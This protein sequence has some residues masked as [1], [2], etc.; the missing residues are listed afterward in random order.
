MSE[1]FIYRALSIPVIYKLSQNIFGPRGQKDLYVKIKKI[2]GRLPPGQNLLDVGCGPSSWLWNEDRHPVGLD[3]YFLYAK[4]F[5]AE[6]EESVNGSAES[7]PFLSA[8][9]DGVWSFGL[10]HHL[11]DNIAI[12]AI[13]EIFRVT[14]SGG[15]CV[16]FDAVLPEPAWR[17]PLPWLIRKIDRGCYMR[18]QEEIESLL[19]LGMH[20]KSERFSYSLYGLEG[21]FCILRKS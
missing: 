14:R 21:I 12:K 8:V 4:A 1:K 15:Y 18:T 7:L 10:L 16:I 19:T 6:G 13:N 3:L 11:P 5:G 9:F 2:L 20:W 17:S